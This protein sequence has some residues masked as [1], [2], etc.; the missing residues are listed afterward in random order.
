MI[1]YNFLAT[2]TKLA[3]NDVGAV[4]SLQ[5]II[6]FKKPV[7]LC[8]QWWRRSIES[9]VLAVH[10]SL[11]LCTVADAWCGAMEQSSMHAL[12]CCLG[13]LLASSWTHTQRGGVLDKPRVRA[14]WLH[15]TAQ[16]ATCLNSLLLG[17]TLADAA[18]AMARS[19]DGKTLRGS[20]MNTK[21]R[22]E[23]T[24]S[25]SKLCEFPLC[26]SGINRDQRPNLQSKLTSSQKLTIP[27]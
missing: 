2:S 4:N 3:A 26:L 11:R 7:E 1:K 18:C 23:F 21:F 24:D 8:Q 14:S 12:A 15:R 6:R 17:C 20:V 25:C 22:M 10:L 16:S 9:R 5:P 27:V 19:A 13:G